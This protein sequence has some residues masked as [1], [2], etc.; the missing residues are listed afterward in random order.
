MTRSPRILLGVSGGIAAYKAV[1]VL[2]GLTARGA[3]V[4]VAMTRGA[5]EFI[6]PLTFSV[7]SRH[8]VLTEVWSAGNAPAVDHVEL[9]DACDLLLV[10][11]ATAHTLARLAHGMADDLVTTVALATRAPLLVAP[12]MNVN[13]EFAT[14]ASTYW[15][16]R[17]V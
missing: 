4:R 2:R 17:Q 10:A 5:R 11:P 16:S 3:D 7:L 14:T 9:A 13:E 12:A 15:A 1:E 6:A 8:E